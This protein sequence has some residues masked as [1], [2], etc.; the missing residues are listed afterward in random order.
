MVCAVLAAAQAQIGRADTSR[1]ADLDKAARQV[2]SP[3]P[4]ES[5]QAI[6]W[7]VRH[8]DRN[9]VAVLIQLLRWLPEHREALVARLEALTDAHVGPNWFDWMLWQQ[10]HLDFPR[11]PGY[12]GFLADLLARIDTRF[13]RFVYEGIPH[14]IRIEEIA[15]GGVVVDGIPALDNPAMIG[16]S[17]ASYLNPDDP[18]FGVDM[19]G[20][21]RAYPLRIANWH[22]MVNDVVGGVPVSLAYCTLCGSGILFDGR[23]AGRTEPFTFGS[24]G[25]LYRS[26]KLM[27][28]RQ[29]DSLWEQFAG[30]PVMGKL[31]GSKIEL[32][33]LP[34]V[35]SSWSE[36]RSRHPA[37]RVLSLDTG[38]R[39]DYGPGGAYREYFASP[40]LMF[41]ALVK[42][43]RLRQKDLIFGVRVPGGVKAWPLAALADGAVINDQIGFVDVVV[44]GDVSGLGARAYE[45]RRRRFTRGASPGE[46]L[47][48]DA[49]WR[50]T[51]GAL[52]G[53]GG[54]SLPRLPGH[55]AY[56]F[57]WAGY[58][59]GA[60][61]G[62]P[63]P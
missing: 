56:W 59:E 22:E 6:D 52:V 33:L 21:A 35:L 8:G 46:V 47:A 25:L 17:A 5:L 34:L 40:E 3:A 37:T 49:R 29:T 55:V 48:G 30:R 61:L 15:W 57:A 13:R 26:N 50:I 39:R 19:N 38:F 54:E 16:A 12:A 36:W 63:S 27:Y 1:I 2:L 42:D 60:L 4:Q 23:I 58:F 62:G 18:V 28:D 14:E 20:D 10:D 41:P 7:L 11:Y 24:S 53:P 43:R 31:A 51:E 44:I 45:A 9:S 32:K